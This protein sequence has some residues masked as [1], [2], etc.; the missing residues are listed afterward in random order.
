MSSIPARM[1]FYD[2]YISDLKARTGYYIGYIPNSYADEASRSNMYELIEGDIE[3]KRCSNLMA[4][5]VAG[6][7]VDIITE[8]SILHDILL[9]LLNK[10]KNYDLAVKSLIEKSLLYGL[11]IQQKKYEKINY[12]RY[13]QLEWDVVTQLN[14][15][16]R[17]RLR[18]ERSTEDKTD[19][20]WTIWSP[21]HDKYIII[22]D[23]DINENAPYAIQDYLWHI[24]EYEELFPYFLGLGDRLYQYVYTK[25]T[26]YQYWCDLCESWSKPYTIVKTN[27]MKGALNA[28]AGEGF[29]DA[30]SRKQDI[31]D[32][33]QKNLA[34]HLVVIDKTGDE[35]EFKEQGTVGNNVIKDFMIYLDKQIRNVFFAT[36]L[37]LGEGEDTSGSYALGKIHERESFYIVRYYRTI[38]QETLNR[39]YLQDLIKRNWLNFRLLGIP[40]EDLLDVRLKIKEKM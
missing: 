27:M 23:R 13:P 29:K 38:L 1:Q 40:K 11:G 32:V 37:T 12:L 36:Q 30:E 7:G 39:D 8:N 14:E 2:K 20:Y 26:I 34:R 31:L 33:F 19:I 4:I 10:N 25:A 6:E 24:H 35:I 15:V 18:I 21:I 28:Q 5:L 16:D 22:E 9:Y 17:R 3:V